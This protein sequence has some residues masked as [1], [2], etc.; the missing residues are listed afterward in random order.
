M[1]EKRTKK[2]QQ[3]RNDYQVPEKRAR[4]IMNVITNR[5][6]QKQNID[7]MINAFQKRC[8]KDQPVYV[9]KICN[10]IAFKSQVIQFKKEKYDKTSLLMALPDDTSYE[11]L[12]NNNTSIC[13]TCHGNIKKG[14]VPRLA[15]RNKLGLH[16]QPP[17]LSGLNMLERHLISPA[18]PF[19]KMINL[20]KGSQKGIHGQVVCVKSDL[21]N[22]EQ[23]LPR[24]P[25]DESLIRVKLKRK[26]QYTSHH[27]C[28]DINPAKV[29]QALL[30]LKS[31]NPLY[32]DI[33]ID[34]ERFNTML[35]DQLIQNEQPQLSIE[36]S[37]EDG[38]N[39]DMIRTSEEILTSQSNQQHRNIESLLP[40]TKSEVNR[41]KDQID[42]LRASESNIDLSDES[43]MSS[44]DAEQ[45]EDPNDDLT[46]TSA[47]LYSFLHPVDF[48]QYLAD[49]HDTTMLSLAPG[50]GNKPEKVLQMEANS[51]PVE[52]PDGQN[53]Y[54][55]ERELKL[56]PSQY[57]K[58]RL[59][60]ADNR[61]ARNPEYIFFAQ[62][63]TEVHQINSGIS[64]AIRIGATK[65]ADGRPITASMLTNHDQVKEIIKRDE[66]Y[67]FLTQVRGTPAFWEKSKK[68]LFAMIRQL[69]IPT[70]FV[71]FSAADRRWIEIPNAILIH[72]GKRPMTAEEHKNMT[73][74]DHCRIIMEN[75]VIA[76]T[77]FYNRVKSFISDVIRSPANPIGQVEDYYY[78]TEFQ[79]RGWPHIHM[80]VWVKD[81]P[82]LDENTD[83]EV[84]EFVDQYI[85]CESPPET[86]SEL[87]EIVNSVQV[88]TK[89]HTKS[90]RKTGKICRFN[91]PKPPSNRT[92]ICRPDNSIEV[93]K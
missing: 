22:T 7:K 50:E 11:N 66:G 69:G 53:T 84:T 90:C 51:F 62:Y 71:T 57:F 36:E 74:E 18:I 34:L 91:F 21:H 52:F 27:M 46:N 77:M 14:N 8:Q 70:F 37:N 60:S 2:V 10:R 59:F 86:D 38:S 93:T 20:I 64:I 1:P 82:K 47:P 54:K 28:Q 83:D 25:T 13:Y 78:R 35:D 56:S 68:N 40:N 85:S 65:T 89:K 80:V 39:L 81:A 4:K 79:Q 49:K 16:I 30:W 26:L 92:F 43:N 29:R 32:E 17:E 42:E 31:N 44:E 24:L 12:S 88:H 87:H 48:A 55:E 76:A 75:P 41:T 5:S 33:E 15:S 19:M 3:A 63:A 45:S 23:C 67:R 73:W 58:T 72:L 9:C 6:E 61:F